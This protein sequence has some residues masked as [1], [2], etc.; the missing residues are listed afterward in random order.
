MAMLSGTTPPTRGDAIIDGKSITLET[1]AAK[2]HV[3]VCFQTDVIWSDLTVG[4]H[5]WFFGKLRGL[6]G[7]ALDNA[8]GDAG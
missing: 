7:R 6:R 8:V 2:R 3:G 1:I 5:L 4:F